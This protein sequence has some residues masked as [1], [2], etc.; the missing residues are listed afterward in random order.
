MPFLCALLAIFA[1]AADGEAA[2]D[3]ANV[4]GPNACAECHKQEVEAWKGSHHFKTFSE[5]PRRKEAN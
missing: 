2:S 5:M 1:F 3:A 4:V